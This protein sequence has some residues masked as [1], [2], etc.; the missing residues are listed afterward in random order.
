MTLFFCH[1]K[2]RNRLAADTRRG[3][4][5]GSFIVLFYF[6]IS[7][8]IELL[9]KACVKGHLEEHRTIPPEQLHQCLLQSIMEVTL[10]KAV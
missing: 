5:F 3:F 4:R 1:P 8:N 10:S 6:K 2:L 7:E 9:Y